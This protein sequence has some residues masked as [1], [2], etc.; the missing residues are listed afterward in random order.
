MFSAE[1]MLRPIDITR[2]VG[3]WLDNPR[4]AQTITCARHVEALE[5]RYA[6]IPAAVHPLL[7]DALKK[8]D[9][10]QLYT[11]QAEAIDSACAGKHTV[12]VTPTASGKS[13]CFHL[14]VLSDMLDNP[15]SRAIFLYP[16][17]A[18]TADQYSGLHGLIEQLRVPGPGPG[19]THPADIKTFTF[20]GDT[21]ADARV[22]VRE[23]GQIVLTN[24]DMLHAGI[25]PHHTKWLKLFRN[26][27]W[28]VLDE[29]HAYKGIF[30]SHLGNVIRRLKRICAFHGSNPTFIC[31]SATIA[32]P[33]AHAQRLLEEEVTLVNRSGAPRA[34][35]HVLF[36]NPPVVNR[37]LGIRRSYIKVARQ[38]VT[39][40]VT[41]GVPT[42][43]FV[44]SRLNV[45]LLVKYVREELTRR[46]M[47]PDVVQGYRGGYLPL[48]RRRIEAGL[49]SGQIKCVVATN[50]LELGIDVG[51]L[52]AC[53]IAGYPGSV[54]SVWQQS[55]RA[56]RRHGESLTVL[57][58]RSTA[59]D[60][61]VMSNPDYFFDNSPEEARID[62]DNLIVLVDHVKCAAFELPFKTGETYGA[63]TAQDTL[64]VLQHLEAHGVLHRAGELF[65]W[66]NRSYPAN[67][68]SL[69]RVEA[70][71]FTVIE[72]EPGH[73]DRT[74]VIAEVDFKS[75][76]TTLYEHAIYNLDGEQYQVERLDYENHKAYVRKVVPDYFTYAHVNFKVQVLATDVVADVAD[77]G[78]VLV[79]EK[80]VGFKKV[81]FDTHENVGYGEV[82][83][84]EV[85][86]H[87]TATWITVAETLIAKFELGRER[88]V[89]ALRGVGNALHT[90]AML[91]VMCT[92]GDL[93]LVVDEPEDTGPRL[94]LYDNVPGGVGFAERI[95]QIAEVVLAGA[96]DL[97]ARCPCSE[98][99]PS[100]VGAQKLPDRH[101]KTLPLRLIKGLL[102]E[103]MSAAAA[104][105][106]VLH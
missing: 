31:A 45:E 51:E 82:H 16:T 32:N 98:G 88:I 105:A 70:E 78:E 43:C 20:D 96:Y 100:C 52:T 85:Q 74:K 26:L 92:R 49:R 34:A 36:V 87:T 79:T 99:C 25:L 14:P 41:Q 35:R 33:R 19:E 68:V 67:H 86:M 71:N 15:D 101:S 94:Y 90:V 23:M 37:Q 93:G 58:G 77:F 21:P 3:G 57:I 97:I 103:D 61:Y 18:L 63:L 28:V 84:P 7:Q 27:K 9:I 81:K 12:L 60:Q 22:A 11:H 4:T 6:P 2:L 47:N 53:V 1:H 5:P 38:V 54:A 89:D 75:T 72:L 80:V 91:R 95:Q 29:L 66:M 10:T 48:R 13:F 24:P 83:L 65:H 42:I 56:G 106:R 73:G 59:L 30:G 76:H 64:E 40:L 62:A 50:A 55:G 39:D 46:H 69:R 102:G 8:R 17:K 44:L 104:A